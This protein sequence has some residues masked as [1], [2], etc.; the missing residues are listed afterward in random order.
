M[1]ADF[2][3]ERQTIEKALSKLAPLIVSARRVLSLSLRSRRVSARDRRFKI[4]KVEAR[5]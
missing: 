4:L 3:K 2:D 5:W 1:P